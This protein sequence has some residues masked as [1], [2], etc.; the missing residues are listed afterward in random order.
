M[1]PI[2]LVTGSK[3]G[4]GKSLV[5]IALVDFLLLRDERTFLIDADPANAD[6]WKCYKDE[7]RC[8]RINLSACEGW[9]ALGDLCRQHRDYAFAVNTPAG[10][11]TAAKLYGEHLM[12]LGRRI[13]ALWVMGDGKDSVL[14]LKE[15][16]EAMPRAVVHA[17][18]NLHHGDE[19]A[20]SIYDHSSHPKRIAEHGGKSLYFPVLA[21]RIADEIKNNRMIPAKAVSDGVLR[22]T[23]RAEMMRWRACC[24]EMFSEVVR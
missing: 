12:T 15:F 11:N 19:T 24:T 14:L 23:S 2:Y 10:S 21:K 3:G 22:I 6:V 5:S 20:F 4:V 16:M 1:K 8:E 7:L 18:R 17:V 13:I 9:V